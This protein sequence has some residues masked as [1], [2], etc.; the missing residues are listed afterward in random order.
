MDQLLSCLEKNHLKKKEKILTFWKSKSSCH[1]SRQRST[2]WSSSIHVAGVCK[3]GTDNDTFWL[4][5]HGHFF[6]LL[7]WLTIKLASWQNMYWF[8]N[9]KLVLSKIFFLLWKNILI[10]W[11]GSSFEE[12]LKDPLF[13]L[14]KFSFQDYRPDG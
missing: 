10:H 2:D 5:E 8:A 12:D 11:Y 3:M 9:K 13:H 14:E 1:V 7:C 6:W 4:W